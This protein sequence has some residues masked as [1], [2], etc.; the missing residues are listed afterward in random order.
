MS[1]LTQT[2]SLS[3]LLA[4]LPTY[5]EAAQTAHVGAPAIQTAPACVPRE[6]TTVTVLGY[7]SIGHGTGQLTPEA[8]GRQMLSLKASGLYPISLADMVE[9]R[10]GAKQL[11]AHCVLLTFDEARDSLYRHAFPVLKQCGFPFVVFVEGKNLSGT[12]DYLGQEK[13]HEMQQSGAEIGSHSMQRRPAAEWKREELENPMGGQAMAEEEIGESARLIRQA[14]G[15]CIA[16]SYPDGYSDVLMMRNMTPFGYKLAFSQKA[17]KVSADSPA[18]LLPRH[19]VID[20][21]SFV[22]ALPP[23]PAA[24]LAATPATETEPATQPSTEEQTG[25]ITSIEE[26]A[27]DDVAEEVEEPTVVIGTEGVQAT[28]GVLGKRTPQSDWISTSFKAPLVPRHQTRVAV[29]GYHNF[30]NSK[31]VSEMR[32][33]TA[34]FCQQMQYLKDSGISIITMQDFLEWRHGQRCLPARCVLITIDDGWKSVYTDAYPVLKAYGFPYTLFLYTRYINVHGD[35]MTTA[36]IKEMMDNGATIGSHSTNHLYPSSWKKYAQDSPDYAYYV[37]REIPDSGAR[38]KA[39]F[40]NCS[41]YCYPG[42]YHTPPMIA[43]LQA[44]P[45]QAAFTVIEKKVTC[46]EDP[47]LVHRYMVF[48]IDPRIFRRAVNFDGEAGIQPTRQGIKEAE[49]RA[50]AFFPKAFEGVAEAAPAALPKAHPPT[51]P[52]ESKPEKPTKLTKKSPA[53]APSTQPR[54]LVPEP[55]PDPNPAPNPEKSLLDW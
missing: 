3:L 28:C 20:D 29:L 35:S 48:G 6:E 45:F 16:F 5:A 46:E 32:M 19:M 30:S 40:G 7:G 9:W 36:Q 17:G 44:S 43:A 14:Y 27:D 53:A 38:L 31:P 13:L 37:Q 12:E 25:Y 54:T 34:E 1:L 41:T 26:L 52:R 47:Y 23:T 39:M 18:Y 4:A 51:H 49:A 8:F 33:R 50:R 2:L 10:A 55:A 11:P 15:S 24:A 42:G 22:A 21:A